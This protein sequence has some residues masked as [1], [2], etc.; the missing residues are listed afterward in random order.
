MNFNSNLSSLFLFY[1]FFSFLFF[2]S[3]SGVLYSIL[4]DLPPW[5]VVAQKRYRDTL[6]KTL[7]HSSTIVKPPSVYL[8]KKTKEIHTA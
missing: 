3:N 1:F 8:N 6:M 7:L 4:P 5:N 2:K